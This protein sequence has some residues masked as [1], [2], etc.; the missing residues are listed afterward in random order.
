M[1]SYGAYEEGRGPILLD[2]VQCEGTETSLLSC[3]HSEWGKHDCS[4]SEDVGVRCELGGQTNEIP[5]ILHSIGTYF[6]LIPILV[7]CSTIFIS[8]IVKAS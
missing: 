3:T 4:H 5:N 8:V 2:E 7:L 6:A 1:A